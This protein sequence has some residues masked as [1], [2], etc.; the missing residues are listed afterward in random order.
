M[1]VQHRRRVGAVYWVLL[2]AFASASLAQDCGVASPA[3]SPTAD[4]VGR[5]RVQGDGALFDHPSV[6]QVTLTGEIWK[7]YDRMGRERSPLGLPR[8]GVVPTTDYAGEHAYFERGVMYWSRATGAHWIG[9]GPILDEYVNLGRQRGFL[10]W[11]V[12]DPEVRAGR[13]RCRFQSGELVSSG[14]TGVVVEKVEFLVVAPRAF[15]RALR[16]LVAHKNATGMST[17]LVELEYVSDRYRNVSRDLPEALKRAIH[18]H[19]RAFGTKYVL[20]VGDITKMPTRYCQMSEEES[21]APGS[22][23]YSM[24]GYTPTDLYYACLLKADGTFDSWD[25][26]HN[27]QFGEIHTERMNFDRIDLHPTVAV[28]RLA[29]SEPRQVATYVQKVIRYER[30]A[31]DADW[32]RRAIVA[33]MDWGVGMTDAMSRSLSNLELTRFQEGAPPGVEG[34]HPLDGE[35]LTEVVNEGVLFAAYSGHGWDGG[36]YGTW[37][38]RAALPQLH[39]ADRLPILFSSACLTLLWTWGT[40]L[41]ADGTRC[42]PTREPIR[43][44]A[45]PPLTPA[46]M[47]PPPAV[48]DWTTTPAPVDWS[49]ATFL[50]VENENGA[51]AQFGFSN[52]AQGGFCDRLIQGAL[53]A[54]AGGSRVA[55]D[56]W[57]QGVCAYA[58]DRTLFDERSN[59]IVVGSW[60]RRAAMVQ[61]YKF[62][63]M[64]D[65]SLRIGGVP[66]ERAR[67]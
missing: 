49:M 45:E 43:H 2:G 28:A 34:I 35:K 9:D 38:A 50:L 60:S 26:N 11:P 31:W 36:W 57:R 56:L 23:D 33:G 63:L 64:G 29:A 25:A 61:P 37:D 54:Y 13:V 12:A 1:G 32:T 47:Q 10:G 40:P 7:K 4:G 27:D 8:T 30:T 41:N 3:E 24:Y 55:G 19:W 6:G 15:A 46:P 39:N 42:P 16:P 5:V 59:P 18:D 48:A 52:V 22:Y 21:F 17:R 62:V 58:D 51:I 44:W 20:L 53:G 67:E 65:P 66:R 14:E